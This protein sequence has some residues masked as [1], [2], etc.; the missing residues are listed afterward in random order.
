[1]SAAFCLAIFGG[2]VIVALAVL[3][4]RWLS[5]WWLSFTF[6][7]AEREE[8]ARGRKALMQRMEHEED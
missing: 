2:A 1:M 8:R 3:Y 6:W 7:M 4:R 5:A